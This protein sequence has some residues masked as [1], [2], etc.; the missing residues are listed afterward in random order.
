MTNETDAVVKAPAPPAPDGTQT[1]P[2][3]GTND[4]VHTPMDPTVAKTPLKTQVAAAGAG[5]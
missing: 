1:Q 4:N 5:K 2:A 3:G